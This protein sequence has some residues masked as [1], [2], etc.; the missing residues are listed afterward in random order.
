MIHMFP[1]LSTAQQTRISHS[2]L[3]L[4]SYRDDETA[5]KSGLQPARQ[6]P[7]SSGG[8]GGCLQLLAFLL[9]TV[10]HRFPEQTACPPPSSRGIKDRP[11][12]RLFLIPDHHL[13]LIAFASMHP[14]SGNPSCPKC[15]KAV[16]AAE[17][18]S[19]SIQTP[20]LLLFLELISVSLIGNGSRTNGES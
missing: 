6:E 2:R 18:V 19:Q 13:L 14:F 4:Q 15:S 10:S 20:N 1:N 11:S 9:A 12:R 17:Q 8:R 3:H 7:K 16:Y 5:P